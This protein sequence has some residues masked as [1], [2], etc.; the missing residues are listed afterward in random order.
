MEAQSADFPFA[1]SLIKVECQKLDK[2]DE[3]PLTRYFVSSHRAGSAPEESSAQRL[4]QLARGHWNIENG[5][6]RAR[7]VHWREDACLIRGHRPAHILATLR[8]VCL[9]LV[10]LTRHAGQSVA[11]TLRRFARQIPLAIAFISNP[12]RE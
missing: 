2:A 11:T 6:H 8:Q 4:A 9:H 10:H 3:T 7:D 5:S 12:L 1:Q